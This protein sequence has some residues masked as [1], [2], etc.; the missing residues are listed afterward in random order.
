MLLVCHHRMYWG[1]WYCEHCWIF[2]RPKH[3]A[4]LGSIQ[5]SNPLCPPGKQGNEKR[6]LG[7]QFDQSP[8]SKKNGK[9]KGRGNLSLPFLRSPN[10]QKCFFTQRGLKQARHSEI[11]RVRG[12]L[13]L[14]EKDNCTPC[15]I[16]GRSLFMNRRKLLIDI[17]RLK[18]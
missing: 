11:S 4:K 15:L 16:G 14:I 7:A 6:V 5:P 2:R 18:Y 17:G 3:S 13:F 10:Q 9:M 8:S 12:S 1:R